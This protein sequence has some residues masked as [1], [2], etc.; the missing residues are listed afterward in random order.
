VSVGSCSITYLKSFQVLSSSP[1]VL[2]NKM[3]Y[4]G[5]FGGEIGGPGF[6]IP[7]AGLGGGL[8]LDLGGGIGG[9]G[10]LLGGGLPGWT[11]WGGPYIPVTPLGALGGIKGQLD[12]LLFLCL[13]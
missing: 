11:G 3:A 8:N 4:P 7:G 13:F 5:G 10:G 1:F 9:G 6:G 12:F 2:F